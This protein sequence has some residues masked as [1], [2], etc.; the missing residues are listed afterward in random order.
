[1]AI[2]EARDKGEMKGIHGS[3]AELCEVDDKYETAIKVAAGGRLQAIIV[4]DDHTG[5]DCIK[6]LKKKNLGRAI[7]LPLRK[8]LPGRPRGKAVLA[9]KDSLG[10][11]VDLVKFDDKFRNAFWYVFTDTIIVENLKEARKLMG[12][13]RIAT[14]QG[15]LIEASGAMI[16]GTLR[17][18]ALKFG[19]PSQKEVK[20]VAEKLR[21]AIEESDKVAQE[22]QE[23]RME[24][25]GS[26]SRLRD[27]ED[28]SES[29]QIKVS[30]LKAKEKEFRSKVKTL[31]EETEKKKQELQEAEEGKAS[32]EEEI[33]KISKRLEKLTSQRDEEKKKIVTSSPEELQRK[34]AKLQNEKSKMLD[35]RNEIRSKLE[36]VQTQVT[37]VSDRL[38][39]LNSRMESS[40][41]QIKDNTKR[42]RTSK[43]KHEKLEQEIR[44]MEKVEDSMG[45][46][47]RD[48]RDKRD[49]AYRI[50]T[51]AEG[52][53]DKNIHQL[54]TKEDFILGLQNELNVGNGKLAD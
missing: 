36:T 30:A 26:E 9:K 47:V 19:A 5:E 17:K 14:I 43:E 24:M 23:V 34:I 53:I 41:E 6:Y 48:L 32:S 45:K 35:E 1:M 46:E 2:L 50:K 37:V 39:E 31:E 27:A 42:I 38:E 20:N 49:E 4:D 3:V 25:Q 13:V 11:A 29:S 15:E 52:E 10:Y 18:T 40:R 12:G 8:M 16:G 51:S 21:K 7:F 44:A 22:L 28:V 33:E 54:H